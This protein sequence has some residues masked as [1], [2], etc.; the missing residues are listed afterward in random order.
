MILLIIL[1]LFSL[2]SFAEEADQKRTPAQ[3]ISISTRENKGDLDRTLAL[4]R[5]GKYKEAS[6]QLFQ[7][8]Y[9]PRYANRRMQIKYLL[10]LMLYS[11]KLNQVSAFQFIS[12]VKEGNNKFLKQSLEK[13]SLAADTL[14]DDTL[15]NYAIS[16]INIDEFPKANRDMVFYRI[17]E[18]QMRNGQFNEAAKTFAKVTPESTYF[19]KTK[20]L[21]GL[22]YAEAKNPAQAISSFDQLIDSRAQ[23]SVTDSSKV[24]A[25]MGKARALYQ[26]KDWDAAIEAYRE[27]PRDT[28]FWHDTLFESSW[29]MLRSGQFRS[30]ISNFQSLHSSYYED[31]YLPESLLL[32]AIVYLYICKFDEMEKVLDL[33]S[34]IYKPVYRDIE[35]VFAQ[36]SDPLNYFNEVAR[37]IHDYNLK[38]DEI[39]KTAYHLPFLVIRKVSREADFRNSYAYIKK[40]I[41]EQKLINSMSKDWRVSS[42]G[43]YSLKVVQTRLQKARVRAGQQIKAHL[44]EVREELVDLFEQEGFIR[45][46]MINGKKESL[47]K[48]IAGKELPTEA[49]KENKY[50]DFSVQNGWEFWPFRGEYWLS[51]LGNYHYVGTQS[52]E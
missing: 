15:L 20:Y 51:E 14:G 32:R 8:S 6:M 7:L 9:S 52:C 1:N 12:V 49:V 36:N 28:L 46:E 25:E 11:M 23:K 45:Y 2:P 41:A 29:A 37:A 31:T 27:I 22:S 19:S 17:G 21:E 39:D 18:F 10:G 50:R 16:R 4:A 35:K 3:A 42:I 43:K 5:A 44:E 24:A 48:R 26:K 40:L 47:K 13:L 38:G 33:Y 30:A 34:K